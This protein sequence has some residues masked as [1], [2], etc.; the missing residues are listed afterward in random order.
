MMDMIDKVSFWASTLY[1]Y[2]KIIFFPT[3][4]L[5]QQTLVI[6]LF[7]FLYVFLKMRGVDMIYKYMILYFSLLFIK[8]Y[9]FF[10][11]FSNYFFVTSKAGFIEEQKNK[12]NYDFATRN[13]RKRKAFNIPRE[14][15]IGLW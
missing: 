5:F 12:F 10:F 9:P 7:F 11:I 6:S 3:Y 2:D 4:V 14:I 1:I 15:I 13:I 8:A